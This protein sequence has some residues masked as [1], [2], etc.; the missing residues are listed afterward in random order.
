[1]TTA[2]PILV[3]LEATEAPA[4][5]LESLPGPGQEAPV[6]VL[7][8]SGVVDPQ[9]LPA[10][11]R[12][13]KTGDYL[14]N[15]ALRTDFLAFLDAWPKRK[16]IHG[17]S[18]D[19]MFR[20]DGGYSV[21]WTGP[22]V[23]RN[24]D[25]KLFGVVRKLW[26]CCRAIDEVRPDTT[27]VFT[28]DRAFARMIA[29]RGGR[30]IAFLAGSAIPSPDPWTRRLRWLAG[31]LLWCVGSPCMMLIRAAAA[32]ILAGRPLERRARRR[33]PA[34]VMS[35]AF[36]RHVSDSPEGSR[37]WYWR[38]LS[39]A[40][41]DTA[42]DVRQRYLMRSQGVQGRARG[43]FTWAYRPDWRDLRRI[44][45]LAPIQETNACLW[46]SLRLI[47]RQVAAL[48]RYWRLERTDAFRKS[49]TFAGADVSGLYVPRLRRAVSRMA[50]WARTAQAIACSL[51]AV[52]NVK[53]M[54]VTEEFYGYGMVDIA[55]ARK[56]GIP[57][58]GVQHGTIFPMHLIYTPPPGQIEG[59]P[60]PDYFAV[61]GE[62]AA[63][64][65][66]E[67][68]AFPRER[69]W[70]TG[71]PRFD[72]LVTDP[73]DRLAVRRRLG[74]P[75]DRKVVLLATQFYPWFQE[76]G[77]V[78][79]EATRDREDVVVCVKT[80]PKD[81]P[82]DVYR[83][84]ARSAGAD[85]VRFFAEGFDELLA[86]C[87]VLISGSSTTVF[88]A[89][90]LGRKTVCVNFSGEPDRYPYAADGGSV[91]ARS[92][93]EVHAA[94]DRVLSDRSR[95]ELEAG[96]RRFLA[97]HA[98][99]AAEGKAAEELARLVGSLVRGGSLGNHIRPRQSNAG[100]ALRTGATS[101]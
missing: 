11:C 3:V 16:L 24:P 69:V 35:A 84:I 1:M 44:R 101:R 54:L 55:A 97:R 13:V 17:K 7:D 96:R 67:Y 10:G 72:H 80:H 21:W 53:A 95:D 83:R 22:A 20:Q 88:E 47:P 98:G 75:S 19:E 52:G 30:K 27:L 59:A 77:R 48:I 49:F 78:L 40:I 73:P 43:W 42:P 86:A 32:R 71:G 12:V 65:I 38:E 45:D 46:T 85:N 8:L 5:L 66:S 58:V 70:V 14:D 94:L 37:I 99:P 33:T 93:E 51:R 91:A 64:V 50:V 79:F 39:G 31:S 81:V 61:Y 28:R 87:D 4:G 25:G 90:L 41:A 26:I 9:R 63:E 29:A 23:D 82:L 36:P 60:T 76:V 92:V 2:G 68:G 100:T 62:F 15:D 6:T 89:I 18:F 56:L 57:T 74:L 34:V